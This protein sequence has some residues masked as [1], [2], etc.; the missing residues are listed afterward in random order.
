[1]MFGEVERKKAEVVGDTRQLD[2]FL[3]H[4][5]PAFGAMRNRPQLLALLQSGGKGGEK[6]SN[7]K[8]H[9]RLLKF[10]AA[11]AFRRLRRDGKLQVSGTDH[12][13]EPPEV[14]M[15][16]AQAQAQSAAGR[17][18]ELHFVDPSSTGQRL[19][20]NAAGSVRQTAA[21]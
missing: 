14:S 19:S 9:I 5:L 3:E 18:R 6:R 2:N 21:P 13:S 1:M 20:G 15:N 12:Q 7:G 17:L 4:P 11:A 16:L 10:S 8:L